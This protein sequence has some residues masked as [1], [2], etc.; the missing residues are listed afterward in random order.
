M[1]PEYKCPCG[2]RDPSKY[3]STHKHKCKLCMSADV[4]RRRRESEVKH[5]PNVHLHPAIRDWLRA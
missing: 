2:D 4:M 5:D 1:A 3:Y